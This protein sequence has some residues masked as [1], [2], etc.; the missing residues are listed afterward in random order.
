MYLTYLYFKYFTT[1]AVTEQAVANKV[2]HFLALIFDPSGPASYLSPFLWY[3]ESKF[4]RWPF[5][6]GWPNPSAKVHQKGRWLTTHLDL[7]SYQTSSPCIDPRRRYPLQKILRANKKSTQ[8]STP[9][10]RTGTY[11]PHADR[12]HCK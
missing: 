7:P 10:F 5:H 3:L 4:W 2:F 11:P 12:R 1:L 6:L 8:T 9:V